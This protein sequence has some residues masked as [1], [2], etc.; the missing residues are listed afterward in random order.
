MAFNNK[1]LLSDFTGRPIPQQFDQANDTYTP[2]LKMEYYGKS[3]DV[4]PLPSKTPIGATYLEIDTKKV[5]LNDG[6][7][8]SV[9]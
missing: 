9:M 6:T 8:W 7:V 2:I 4:K 5:Y 3:T 1:Q